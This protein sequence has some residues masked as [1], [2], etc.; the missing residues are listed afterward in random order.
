MVNQGWN[1]QAY[2]DRHPR[3]DYDRLD[4]ILD[5]FAVI[6]ICACLW[7]FVPSWQHGPLQFKWLAVAALAL[8]SL[9]K[10]ALSIRSGRTRFDQVDT[11]ALL[12][13]MWVSI[14]LLW[15]PN[16][17]GGI[18]TAIKWALLTTIFLGLR[19]ESGLKAY[20]TLATGIGI[21][22]VGI[23]LIDRLHVADFGSY[24]NPN[25]QTEALLLGLPFLFVFNEKSTPLWLRWTS[26]VAAGLVMFFLI[27]VNPSKIEFL[28]VA[29]CGIVFAL[30]SLWR[31]SKLKAFGILGLIVLG[32]GVLVFLA[33]DK[34][35]LSQGSGF[36]NSIYPRL[37]LLANG[38]AMWMNAPLVGHGAGFIY[39][40]YP[41]FQEHYL[42]YFGTSY[43]SELL[44]S[45]YVSAGALHNDHIQFLAGFGLVGLAIVF[46]G[47]YAARDHLRQWRSSPTRLAGAVAVTAVLINATI[48]FPFQNAASAMFAMLGL[49]WL[50]A[51]PVVAESRQPAGFSSKG[52][53]LLP[54]TLLIAA[55][56]A[57]G[58]GAYRYYIA[59][60]AFGAS[61]RIGKLRP[62]IA[63]LQLNLGAIGAYPFDDAIRYQAYST[64]M[65]LEENSA[66]PVASPEMHDQLF[67]TSLT[68]G[69]GNALLIFRLEY[70]LY[71]GRYKERSEEVAKWRHQLTT[72]VSRLPDTWL[73]EG[74]YEVADNHPDKAK[75]A[76]DRYLRLTG[77]RV[78]DDRRDIVERIRQGISN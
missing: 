34:P 65:F 45:L 14:S 28:V 48:D 31:K 27:F 55:L 30:A 75:E 40:V 68:T 17:L 66:Q 35:M 46:G 52:W 2:L 71:S 57:V 44:T 19:R 69:P 4:A 42:H 47:I 24:F 33:W 73:M 39:P 16:R 18:D 3:T 20:A 26:R 60:D 38:I 67:A 41:L 22:L 70:L 36:R 37:E 43:T 74:L 78:T 58:W 8:V 64:L 10:L 51:S 29:G 61:L 77:G 25:Y 9:G 53:G 1:A 21:G 59:H 50:T 15:T 13:L 76:L 23:L 54:L 32:T 62:D 5:W 49:A 7:M 12:L 11:F 56:P 63:S 72:N 6:S